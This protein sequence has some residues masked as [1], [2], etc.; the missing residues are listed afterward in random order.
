MI[1]ACQL[2]SIPKN[3]IYSLKAQVWMRWFGYSF[4]TIWPGD[5]PRTRHCGL[6]EVIRERTTLH[7]TCLSFF[8][9]VR[10][11]LSHVMAGGFEPSNCG[12]TCWNLQIMKLPKLIRQEVFDRC[13]NSCKISP[14]IFC[15]YCCN[16]LHTSEL[17]WDVWL[18]EILW[19]SNLKMLNVDSWSDPNL[20]L[21]Y[22][23]HT[24]NLPGSLFCDTFFSK[25]LHHGSHFN[26]QCQF[27]MTCCR[28]Q[29]LFT[30]TICCPSQSSL[31][32][33]Y[34]AGKSGN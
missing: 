11:Y 24:C 31:N 23:I 26:E 8:C 33:R 5:R 15:S 30:I 1:A 16:L 17:S 3:D 9:S 27:Y 18:E 13:C 19:T 7:Q 2:G 12:N 20:N 14:V 10:W 25:F 21:S 29:I 32:L 4:L 6:E 22:D 34:R 28:P